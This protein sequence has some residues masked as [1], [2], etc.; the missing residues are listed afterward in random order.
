MKVNFKRLTTLLLPTFLRKTLISF[1]AAFSKSIKT[2]KKSIDK[3][4]SDLNYHISVTPQVFSLEKMLNDKCDPYYREI[5]IT[6]PELEARFY[7][8]VNTDVTMQYFN[9]GNFFSGRRFHDFT[10]FLPIR[11][12]SVD[13][14]NYVTALLNKYKL[15]T[16]TFKIEY[17]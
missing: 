10:V 7:F 5:K 13:M 9:D 1:V 6:I 2:V 12:K 15:L 14:T 4:F 17:V 11:I 8:S 3:F 16:K